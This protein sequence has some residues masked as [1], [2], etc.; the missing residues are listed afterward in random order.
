[1][2]ITKKWLKDLIKPRDESGKLKDEIEGLKKELAELKLKK[3][4]EEREI[5]HLVTLKQEKL[6]IEFEK[7]EIVLQKEFQK[8]ELDLQTS[9]HDKIMAAINTA[10][11]EM[12][13]TYKEIL[14]RLPNVNVEL[15]G[16]R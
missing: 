9:Y 14:K 3:I 12:N 5:K 16:K 1:M 13:A 10:K 7:K 8:K 15:K 6:A 2:F 11:E 4:M